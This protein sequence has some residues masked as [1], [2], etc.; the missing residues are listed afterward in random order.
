VNH[1]ED[2]FIGVDAGGT[3]TR[4]VI[5]SAPR[6]VLGR[7]HAGAADYRIAPV[8][9]VSEAIRTAIG[10]A[11]RD[12]EPAPRRVRAMFIGCSG[13]E[14]PGVRSGGDDATGSRDRSVQPAGEG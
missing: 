10:R 13:L 7:G 14:G 12:A 11:P 9:H 3:D 2:W 8:S 4:A 5:F 1:H 6:T